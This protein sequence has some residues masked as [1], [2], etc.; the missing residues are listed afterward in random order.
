MIFEVPFFVLPF[1]YYNIIDITIIFEGINYSRSFIP[2]K[3]YQHFLPFTL[4]HHGPVG[5]ACRAVC[6]IILCP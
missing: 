5:F 4:R 6:F 3:N 2:V 1:E